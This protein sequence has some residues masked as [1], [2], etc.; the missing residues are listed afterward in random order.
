MYAAFEENHTAYMVMEYLRG[1]SLEG[2]LEERGYLPEREAVGY[3][4]RIGR[5]CRSSMRPTCCTAT[6][7][8]ATSC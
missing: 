1:T 6:S 7:S 2:L 4:A 8:R 3:I 5:R